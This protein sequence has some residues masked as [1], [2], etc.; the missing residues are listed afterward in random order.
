MQQW[1]SRTSHQMQRLRDNPACADA[2]LAA[3]LDDADPGQSYRLTF[4]SRANIL[5]MTSSISKF[6]GRTPKVAI[7]R[8]QGVNG[9]AEMAFAFKTAGFDAV[10]VHMTDLLAGRPLSDFVG[11]AV[12]DLHGM[13]RGQC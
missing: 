6:F 7:L 9:H 12:S 8:E 5:P 13:K 2:E 10:D 4:E 11:I 1:W 3:A